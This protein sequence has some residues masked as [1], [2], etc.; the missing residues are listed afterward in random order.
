MARIGKL[1]F[2]VGRVNVY[3]G[4]R[5]SRGEIEGW[6]PIGSTRNIQKLNESEGSVLLSDSEFHL[7]LVHYSPSLQDL[8]EN[9]D[10]I[11][12][13]LPLNTDT[14]GLINK[15]L[16]MRLP[17]NA[18]LVNT[19]RAEVVNFRELVEVLN[20]DSEKS[21]TVTG[22]GPTLR[23]ATDVGLESSD[24]D[25]HSNS[26]CFDSCSFR[27]IPERVRRKILCTPSKLAWYTEE[28]QMKM[29]QRAVLNVRQFLEEGRRVNE[30]RYY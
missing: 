9:S 8:F 11:S 25:N 1:G 26:H 4:V 18:V 20:L 7:P 16:L 19:A 21:E 3:G 24:S 10:I 28:A 29:C 13:N 2:G 5:K 14:K 6:D 12:L 23:Y 17:E 15:Q 27:E 30:V 22:P